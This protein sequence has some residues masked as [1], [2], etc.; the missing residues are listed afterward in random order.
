VHSDAN[1][2]ENKV[3]FRAFALVGT[4]HRALSTEKRLR[5]TWVCI[6]GLVFHTPTGLEASTRHS[7]PSG[8]TVSIGIFRA[9]VDDVGEGGWA[10]SWS[11]AFSCDQNFQVPG[12]FPARTVGNSK[13]WQVLKSVAPLHGYIVAA[14]YVLNVLFC[15]VEM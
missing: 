3:I 6:S 15:V 10:H 12:I 13:E 5:S 9:R 1:A 14:A 11:T 2:L 8:S 7:G 4:L